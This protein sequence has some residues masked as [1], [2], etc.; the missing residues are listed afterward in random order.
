MQADTLNPYA[1]YARHESRFFSL[2]KKK[3]KKE[4]MKP[5][6]KDRKKARKK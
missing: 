6:K 2:M 4:I 1:V 5:R 3:V